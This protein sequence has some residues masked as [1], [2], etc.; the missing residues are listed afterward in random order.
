M[1][2]IAAT[3]LLQQCFVATILLKT[4]C[5][6]VCKRVGLMSNIVQQHFQG[7]EVRARQPLHPQCVMIIQG[8]MTQWGVN[9]VTNLVTS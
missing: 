1:G 5:C 4:L 8:V 2:N 9:P 3:K 6:P 7:N